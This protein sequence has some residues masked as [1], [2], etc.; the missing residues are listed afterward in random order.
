M[1]GPPIEGGYRDCSPGEDRRDS[2]TSDEEEESGP[3]RHHASR[4]GPKQV[5]QRIGNLEHSDLS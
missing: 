1:N 5:A 4:Q 2:N 3:E